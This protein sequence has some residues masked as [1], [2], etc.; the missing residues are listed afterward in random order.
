MKDIPGY[1]TLYA[2]TE[3]GRIW[4]HPKRTAVG[5]N[6]GVRDDGGRWLTLVRV[7]ARTKHL[8]AY[9]HRDGKTVGMLVHRAVALTYIPNPDDLPHINH[10]DGDPT[11]N[12]VSN[13]EWCDAAAN[14]RH[15][16]ANGL[17]T[18]PKQS[19][20]RNS[21]SKLTEA[22]VRSIRAEHADG[23]SCA[24]IARQFGLNPKTVNDI[25]RM[26]RWAHI[27]Q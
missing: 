17:T 11:N 26:K 2:V 27:S 3:D 14:A 10:K 9:L 21:Q 15:A 19:G 23:Q 25:V 5:S 16:V 1:E 12:N 13:L 22:D 24:A 6:G 7:T 20:A 8:R 18:M 4:S